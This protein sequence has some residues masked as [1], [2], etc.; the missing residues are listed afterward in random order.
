MDGEGGRDPRPPLSDTEGRAYARMFF[1][2][3]EPVTLDGQGRL[4][5]PQ[6][7]RHEAGSARRRSLGVSDR[8]EIWDGPRTSGTRRH[9]PAP[10]RRGRSP[11]GEG[12]KHEASK[13]ALRGASPPEPVA[14]RVRL[15]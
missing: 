15:P 13:E 9:T 12:M 11:G 3:A 5:V 6:R 10:T 14:D 8:M 2:K 4:L 7:L 1:G